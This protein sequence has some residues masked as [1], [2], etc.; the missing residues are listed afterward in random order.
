MNSERRRLL[1]MGTGAVLATAVRRTHSEV[2]AKPLRRSVTTSVLQ[3]GYLEFGN[4]SDF[5]VLLLHGFPDD[6][7]AYD[8]V[9]PALAKKGFRALVPYLRGFGP[10]RF[11]DPAAPRM[12]EQA[13]IGQDL[14][15]FADALNLKQFAVCG[16]DWGGRAACIAAALNP[17]RIRAAVLIGGY[18]IQDTMRPGPPAPPALVKRLWYQW[19]LNTE[20]GRLGLEQNRR[21]LCKFMWQ[22][23]SPTWHFSDEA[24]G[25]AAQSFE[26][27]DFVDCVVHSYRHRTF[28]APGEARFVEL[29]RK[30]ALRPK[31]EVPSVILYG[32]DSG[33][34]RPGSEAIREDRLQF[35]RLVA[36]R[37]IEGSG[38][39]V[40][41]EKPEAVAAA[42]FQVIE[43]ASRSSHA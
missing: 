41:R 26:N 31:I 29:E 40:P 36:Q 32:G 30:L 22:D 38:H 34:G 13:A 23:W 39:F 10:T 42:V 18:T 35:T 8:A 9:A 15:D 7:H 11:L 24:F 20:A 28:N 16:Y 19:Y 6:A 21:A 3:I 5:P 14:I 25:L 4:A 1:A 27:P 12:A 2:Q 33:F 17:G 37:I 43:H